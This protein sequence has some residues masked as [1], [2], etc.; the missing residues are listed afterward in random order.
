MAIELTISDLRNLD[1]ADSSLLF[2]VDGDTETFSLSVNTLFEYTKQRLGYLETGGVEMYLGEVIP[3]THTEL[4]GKSF[5]PL[6]YPK[7]GA[8]FPSGKL[9]D[10]R[11]MMLKHAPN[12]RAVLS[13]EGEAVKSHGHS[14]SQEAHTHTRGTM[15]ITGGF[16][17]RNNQNMITSALLDTYGAFYVIQSGTIG[18]RP[19]HYADLYGGGGQIAFA[20]SSNWSG[21]TSSSS[22]AIKVNPSGSSKNLVDN[23]AVK[24]IIK[25]A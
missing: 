14:A 24:F 8:L 1:E 15:E 17:M 20:A 23:I 10:T 22:P 2:A 19:D 3:P 13:F 21:S 11:G 7:M 16:A 12:G 18:S 4:D 25:K 5:D 9:P 6:V